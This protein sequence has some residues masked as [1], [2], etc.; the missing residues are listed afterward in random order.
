VPVVKIDMK[1]FVEQTRRMTEELMPTAIEGAYLAALRGVG[2][3]QRRTR[4]APPANPAG[5]GSGGAV[6]TGDFLR[7]WKAEQLSDGA[8]TYNESPYGP[9]IEHGRRAPKKPPPKEVIVRWIQR[10]LGKTEDEARSIAFVVAR[11][12]GKRGLIGRKIAEDGQ[13]EISEIAL[14]EIEKAIRDKFGGEAR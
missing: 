5:K 6:N 8:R 7:R 11:A 2:I 13:D 12:I 9:V 4:E 14:E 1:Q 10:R 3:M